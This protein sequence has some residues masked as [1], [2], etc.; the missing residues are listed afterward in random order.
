MQK[1][2]KGPMHFHAAWN[3]QRDNTYH[4]LAKM[5]P[6]TYKTALMQ[7]GKKCTNAFHAA[8]EEITHITSLAKIKPTTYKT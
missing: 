1:G 4:F 5:K 8:L 7:K 2:K 3:C 6:I